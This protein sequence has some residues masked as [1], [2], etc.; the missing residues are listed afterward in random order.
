MACGGHG[1][2]G[3]TIGCLQR[4]SQTEMYEGRNV[5]IGYNISHQTHII[6]LDY[7]SD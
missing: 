5:T 6:C 7:D 2:P 3:S 4:G 1:S